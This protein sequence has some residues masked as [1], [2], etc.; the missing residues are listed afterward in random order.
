MKEQKEQRES[1]SDR[2]KSDRDRRENAKDGKVRI[3]VKEETLLYEG[4]LEKLQIELLKFQNYVKR[5][6]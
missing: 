6:G 3:W 2:R 5:K 1:K 4:E